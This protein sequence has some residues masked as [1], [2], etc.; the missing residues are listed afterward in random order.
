MSQPP[1][2]RREFFDV[3]ATTMAALAA[4]ELVGCG[5]GEADAAEPDSEDARTSSD[6]LA[7]KDQ[8]PQICMLLFPKLTLLDLIGPYTCFTTV[9]LTPK[10]VWKDKKPIVS[11]DG[12]VVTPTATFAECARAPDVLFVP[13]GGGTADMMRDRDVLAFLR[14]RGQRAGLV[15]SVCTGSLILGAAGLLR[16]YRAT[17]HWTVLDVLP[18]L[19]AEAVEA[20]YVEDRNRITGGGVTSGIDFGLRILERLRGR[21]LA[22]GAQLAME[23]APEPPFSAGSPDTADPLVVE[24]VRAISLPLWLD[25]KAAAETARASF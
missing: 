25:R 1:I 23:Y 18:I 3:V 24:A 11:D 17:S 22:E 16:G 5:D 12:V 19:E 10:L 4:A 21:Q 15:T 20:R 7:R 8:S 9:G 2:K 14:S 13:G 6:A